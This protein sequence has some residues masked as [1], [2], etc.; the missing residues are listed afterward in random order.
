MLSDQPN[1]QNAL[2]DFN[3]A[4]IKASMQE[5]LARLTGKSNEPLS[6]DDV[7][8][9]LEIERAQRAWRA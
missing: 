9:K 1:Y 8:K 6:Y 2:H 7:A 4:R 3:D 5:V